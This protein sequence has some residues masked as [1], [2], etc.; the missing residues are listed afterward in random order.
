MQKRKLSPA[1]I[2]ARSKG[3]RVTWQRTIRRFVELHYPDLD[4]AAQA[5]TGWQRA[6]LPRKARGM[7]TAYLENWIR[8][9]DWRPPAEENAS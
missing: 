4:R 1:Q 5:I 9:N 6:I 8:R 7:T 2:A 3:G